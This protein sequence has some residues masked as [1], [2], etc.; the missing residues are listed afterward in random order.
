MVEETAL[1]LSSSDSLLKN[2]FPLFFI[3]SPRSRLLQTAVGLLGRRDLI[4]GA[5]RMHFVR[6]GFRG[7]AA[8]RG[9]AMRAPPSALRHEV[10][11]F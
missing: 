8:E 6:V 5:I 11:S 1:F 4:E 10:R 9:S 3:L 2:T 7:G